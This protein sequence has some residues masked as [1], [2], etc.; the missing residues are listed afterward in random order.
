VEKPKVEQIG[1]NAFFV[2]DVRTFCTS[3]VPYD[4]MVANATIA[5]GNDESEDGQHRERKPA[6]GGGPH[7]HSANEG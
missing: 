2:S 5:Y 1:Q 3:L 4:P 6:N 7:L